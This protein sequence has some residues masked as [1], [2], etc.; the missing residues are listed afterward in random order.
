MESDAHDA[1]N[2]QGTDEV[3][4]F[5]MKKMEQRQRGMSSVIGNSSSKRRVSRLKRE[6]REGD[7]SDHDIEIQLADIGQTRYNKQGEN[8]KS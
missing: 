6:N 1:A 3:I 8:Y 4:V 5:D 2:G 7:K